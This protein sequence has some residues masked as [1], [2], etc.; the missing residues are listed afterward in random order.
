[1]GRICISVVHQCGHCST[2]R[3]VQARAEGLAE[4]ATAELA[5]LESSSRF[6][7]REKM[8]VVSWEGACQLNPRLRE[9][10]AASG[11]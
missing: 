9:P 4:E 7:A 10:L 6:T 2:V 8:G 11:G 5:A 1:M 3:S